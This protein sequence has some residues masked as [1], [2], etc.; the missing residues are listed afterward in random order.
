V[1]TNDINVSDPSI[2]P[3]GQYQAC[4]VL[5]TVSDSLG[6]TSSDNDCV[7][8]NRRAPYFLDV[9]A[10][11][12]VRG[13]ARVFGAKFRSEPLHGMK[14][15]SIAASR[16]QRL[17]KPSV[18]RPQGGKPTVCSLLLAADSRV[19]SLATSRNLEV[20]GGRARKV[21][22]QPSVRALALSLAKDAVGSLSLASPSRTY[23]LPV[24]GDRR[25]VGALASVRL[26]KNVPA[27][28]ELT[29]AMRR[30]FLFAGKAG[31]KD[32]GAMK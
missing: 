28:G 25:A 4:A 6:D 2:F 5:Y 10:V 12:A 22:S 8:F 11:S 15:L 27:V 9:N 17:A 14:G 30:G 1:G 23:G 18:Y 3:P 32:R 19:M 16:V 26:L 7:N 21:M 20:A 13:Q 31:K 24:D 29:L